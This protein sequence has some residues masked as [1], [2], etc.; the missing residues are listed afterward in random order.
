MGFL[1]TFIAI[2][3]GSFPTGIVVGRWV[4]GRDIRKVGSG[5][6]GAANVVRAAGW[7]AGVAVAAIDIVK[8][9]L[10]VL[11]GRAVGLTPAWLAVVALAAVLGHD[12]SLFLRL[13]G[14]KGVA[15]TLGVCLAL[16]PAPTAVAVVIW[17][18]VFALSRFTSLASLL[19]L[20]ALPAAMALS[21]QPRAYVVL[22]VILLAVGAIK[23]W[24]N[25]IRLAQGKEKG[26]GK[27]H[28]VDGG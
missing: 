3:F 19:A 8:G 20:A 27:P 2:L 21:G 14:G 5:N 6:F 23:H 25:I 22:G 24:E 13:K 16:A 17:V 4:T 15:T 1:V 12:F 10:P 28:A 11:L 7:K 18:A 9:I 26:F